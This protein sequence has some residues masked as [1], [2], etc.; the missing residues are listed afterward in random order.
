MTK[1]QTFEFE[2]GSTIMAAWDKLKDYR[3]KLSAADQEAG[4]IYSDAAMYLILTR[5][6]STDYK[7]TI[8]TLKIQATLS[9]EEK[10]KHLEEQEMSIKEDTEHGLAAFKKSSKYIPPHHHQCS[11]S[12]DS[13]RSEERRVGKECRAR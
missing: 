6:L 3:W 5:S 7:P 10:L 4:K 1:L 9:V 13:D 8:S 2:E 11:R 12:S